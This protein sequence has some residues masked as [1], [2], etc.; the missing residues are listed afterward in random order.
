AVRIGEFPFSANGKAMISGEQV[1]KVKVI[2][3]PEYEEVVGLSICGPHATELV[4]QGVLMLN[5]EMTA[6]LL[7]RLIAAH[8]TVSEAIHEAVLNAQGHPVHV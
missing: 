5:G 6:D 7:E 3:E 8:P 2:I 4:G 1:G